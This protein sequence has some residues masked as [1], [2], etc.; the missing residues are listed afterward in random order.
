MLEMHSK[1]PWFQ[2]CSLK[3][4]SKEQVFSISTYSKA[5]ATYLKTLLNT[6]QGAI[7]M[8]PSFFIVQDT[9]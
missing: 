8:T 7:G 9:K 1:R 3:T 2:N 5:F 4:R 6:L